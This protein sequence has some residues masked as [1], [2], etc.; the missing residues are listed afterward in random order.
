M[1]EEA[2]SLLLGP[3]GE[4]PPP[5]IEAHWP[6]VAAGLAVALALGWLGWLA[7]RR[8]PRTE[9]P[10]DAC[11]RALGEARAAATPGERAARAADALRAYLAA[12]VADAP[13]GL[14]TEQLASRCG[15]SPLLAT[16]ADPVIRAL[17]AADAA[18]FAGAPVDA[19]RVLAQAEEALA[20]V[21]LARRA[22]WKEALR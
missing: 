3:R 13:A 1:S 18:K 21:E 5:W 22:L 15:R 2:A 7:A 9:D 10:A 19:P 4:V 16:A 17:R 14:S 6:L 8:R 12:V 11:R 20:R